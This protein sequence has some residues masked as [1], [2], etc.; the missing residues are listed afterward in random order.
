MNLFRKPASSVP[1]VVLA[2]PD[3]AWKVLATTNEWI[4]HADAKTGVTLAFVGVTGTT[5]FNLVKDEMEWSPLLNILVFADL[6][7]LVLAITFAY[8][9]LS[10]RTKTRAERR[11]WVQRRKGQPQ[12]DA[13][14]AGKAAQ[15]DQIN[16]LFFGH[17]ATHYKDQGPSYHEVLTLI[18]KDRERLTGQIAAQIHENSHVATNKFKYVDRAI[19]AELAAVAVLIGIVISVIVGH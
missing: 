2:E 17:I 14:T 4:R 15:Q 11:K 3:H 9:A 1:E 8:F 7:A 19:K 5:L 6:L 12:S 10:P 13:T 18:T 16:L